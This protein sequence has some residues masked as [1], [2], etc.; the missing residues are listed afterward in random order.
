MLLSISLASLARELFSRFVHAPNLLLALVFLLCSHDIRRMR[1]LLSRSLARIFRAE[2]LAREIWRMRSARV[3]SRALHSPKAKARDMRCERT[4]GTRDAREVKTLASLLPRRRRISCEL[5]SQAQ[6][7]F[8]HTSL[9]H[10]ISYHLFSR[11]R[12]D[13]RTR[14]SSL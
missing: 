2:S 14:A 1:T 13:E 11:E 4:K 3:L 7:V 9:A 12:R 8:R 10:L 5:R 6:G